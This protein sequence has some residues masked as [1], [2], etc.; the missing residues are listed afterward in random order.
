MKQWLLKPEQVAQGKEVEKLYER[1]REQTA[2][3]TEALEHVGKA[4]SA[5]GRSVQNLQNNVEFM[6]QLN[7]VFTYV[8]LPLKMTG[9]NAHGDLYIYTNKKSLAAKDGNVSAVLHLDMEHLGMVDVYVTM[10]NNK[11]GTNFTLED[12]AALDLVA[13]HIDIL[14]KRLADRGYELNAKMSR[15]EPGEDGESGSVMQTMLEQSKNISVLSHTSFD[16]RA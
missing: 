2:R 11:V 1:M 6:N 7:H 4:D 14:E 3:M 13:E 8:Q 15:K 12:D 16:M 5:L 9:N 10:K